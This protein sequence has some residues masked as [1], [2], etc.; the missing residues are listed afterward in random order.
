MKKPGE[1]LE[2]ALWFDASKNPDPVFQA[3]DSFKEVFDHVC[4]MNKVRHGD[5]TFDILKPG[6]DSVPEVPRWLETTKGAVPRL[7]IAYTTILGTAIEA[8]K[9]ILG[10]LDIKD[11]MKLRVIVRN[12]YRMHYPDQSVI[13]DTE[14]DA[15]ID[16]MG[17]EAVMEQLQNSAVH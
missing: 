15:I 3:G 16:N 4:E 17:M 1:E 7:V 6:D 14:C 2:L 5:V 10:D 9:G 11:V 13:T 12:I 8:P